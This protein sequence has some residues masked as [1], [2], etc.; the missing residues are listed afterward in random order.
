LHEPVYSAFQD[1][2]GKDLVVVECFMSLD[3]FGLLP[4][5]DVISERHPMLML[6]AW[7]SMPKSPNAYSCCNMLIFPLSVI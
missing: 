7:Y 4:C 6:R 5:F 3:S 1:M 2:T